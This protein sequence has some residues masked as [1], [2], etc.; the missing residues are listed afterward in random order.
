MNT[1]AQEKVDQA[2]A[3]LQEK[4]ID[5]WLTFVRETTAGGD[6]VLPLIYGHDLTWQSALL[7]GRSGER[8]AIVGNFEAEAA[9]QTGA[10]SGDQGKVIPYH[11]SIRQDLLQTLEELNPGKIAINYSINDVHADGLS[12]GMYQLLRKY[13]EGTPFSERLVSAEGIIGSLRG[14]KTPEEVARVTAA[15]ATT[16]NIFDRT[17]EFTKLGMKE[18][19]I[20]DFM[21]GLMAERDLEP[22]WEINNCPSVNAGPDSPV[23]HL[24]P[25][26]I[27]LQPGHLLHIDFGV[28]QN[29]YCSDIQRTAYF[30]RPGEN[31]APEP[32]RR[33][34]ETVVRAIQEAVA[35]MK[36]GV[37]GKEVDAVA[38]GVVTKAGY[39]EYMYATGHH[40][41]RT[42]HDGAGILGPEWE[43]YG[44]TPNYQLE[45]GHVYT[46]EPGLF[47][48]GYGYIG[49]EED[50]LVTAKG[51]EFLGK[52]QTALIVKE[53]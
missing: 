12:Y 33:G 21:Q 36:P 24:G 18:K 22:A 53:G 17:F 19:Q 6:P 49:L 9:R 44:D 29:E 14:R 38:R 40:L 26:E 10:Y 3:I 1:L 35:A 47:V 50:V 45:A 31:Q 11:Q 48:P 28:R 27:E 52:P 2:I 13:L 32:V 16:L 30:I 5:L 39:P 23:G 34:F 20:A 15:V 4:G 41:G 25:T 7:L 51:A 37:K 42:A 43:R 46:V 8:I